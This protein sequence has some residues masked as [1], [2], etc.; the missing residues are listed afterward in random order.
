M[1]GN[2]RILRLWLNFI[3]IILRT[4]LL[5]YSG[6]AL[7]PLWAEQVHIEKARSISID[8]P[9]G[10][11]SQLVLSTVKGIVNTVM[12]RKLV[13][14]FVLQGS[15]AIYLQIAILWADNQ[16]IRSPPDWTNLHEAYNYNVQLTYLAIKIAFFTVNVGEKKGSYTHSRI[17]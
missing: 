16:L 9:I 6:Y 11:A 5:I 1:N 12:L 17:E 8:L 3:H 4:T 14:S 7:A 15:N 13:E 10:A 2:G